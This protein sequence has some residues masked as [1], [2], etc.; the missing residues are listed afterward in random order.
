[1]AYAPVLESNDCWNGAQKQAFI[2]TY[3]SGFC[4]IGW[5]NSLHFKVAIAS[6]L[7]RLSTVFAVMVFVDPSKDRSTRKLETGGA[8][9][10]EKTNPKPPQTIIWSL[11]PFYFRGIVEHLDLSR[12]ARRSFSY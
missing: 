10:D 11:D 12:F 4:I 8:P 1:M 9:K 2:K 7:S 5:L 6:I 3:A